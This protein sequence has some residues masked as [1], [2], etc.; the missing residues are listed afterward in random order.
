MLGKDQYSNSGKYEARIHLNARFKTRPGSKFKWIFEHF[1]KGEGLRVL[2]LGCGNGLFWLAN[3][4]AIPASWKITLTD[5]SPVMLNSARASLTRLGR[6]FEYEVMDAAN[7]CCQAK[8]FDIIL[9][10]N[11]LYHV[12]ERNTAI[13]NISN[14][15][16][17]GGCFLA[18]TMGNSD[19]RELNQILYDFLGSRN[20]YFRFRENPFSLNNGGEQLKSGFSK[21]D[22]FRYEDSLCITEVKPIVDYYL[23]F[24]GMYDGATVMEET[25]VAPFSEYLRSIL[26]TK[27]EILVTKDSGVFICSQ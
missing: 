7:I 18:S 4:A 23:S 14:V 19:M 2:E 20:K 13:Q 3:R 21:V 5:Y 11:I 1:P 16:K 27:K 26:E 15:L 22:L 25:E 17:D 24:N 9:A 10:N 8:S 6:Q 12:E